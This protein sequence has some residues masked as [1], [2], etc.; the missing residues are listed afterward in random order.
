MGLVEG[1]I[2]DD[3]DGNTVGHS[4]GAAMGVTEGT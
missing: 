1:A 4:E 2:V 3:F